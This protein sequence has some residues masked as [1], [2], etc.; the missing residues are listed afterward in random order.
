MLKNR[1]FQGFLGA[2]MAAEKIYNALPVYF[3][4]H[5]NSACKI[6]HHI[7]RLC[8]NKGFHR[9][10]DPDRKSSCRKVCR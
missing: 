10:F 4:R 8:K 2:E 9:D 1:Y 6:H 7:G 3:Y 5:A